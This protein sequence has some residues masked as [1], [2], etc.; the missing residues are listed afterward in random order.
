LLTGISTNRKNKID[1]KL[2]VKTEYLPMIANW[3]YGEE[4]RW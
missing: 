3:Q 4:G 2:N 1:S